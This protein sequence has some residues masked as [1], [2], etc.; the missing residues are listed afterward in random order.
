MDIDLRLGF[1]SLM[2]D[3]GV[4]AILIR[5]DKQQQCKCV[6]RLSLS[7]KDNCPIC[8]ATGFI[9]KAEKIKVRHRMAAGVGTQ[10]KMGGLAQVG[11]INASLRQFYL[12][13]TERPKKQDLLILCE[14]DGLKPILDEYTEIYEIDSADPMRGDG[15]RIEYFNLLAK[16]DPVNM[17]AKFFNLQQNAEGLTYYITVR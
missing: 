6:D 12:S 5:N 15:G 10:S 1:E 16:S 3:Y 2:R 13:Y 17:T 8:L 14:W 7:P 11:N 4:D 9:N